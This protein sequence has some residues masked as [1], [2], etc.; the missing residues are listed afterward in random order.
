MHLLALNQLSTAHWRDT[1]EQ[2]LRGN[3]QSAKS[4]L[5]C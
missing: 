3:S 1:N 5:T 4:E 2:L